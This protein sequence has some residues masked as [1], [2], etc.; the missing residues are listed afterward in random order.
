MP[1]SNVTT[2]HASELWINTGAGLAK[3]A[4]IDDIPELPTGSERALYETSSFDSVDY[5]EFK[6]EP[7][8]EGVEIEITGNYVINSA[9][10]AILQD[11]D[12]AEGALAYRIVL[13]EGA[14]TYHCEGEALF[15]NLKRMNP[16]AEKRTFSIMMKPVAAAAIDAA[17]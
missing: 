8:K 13:K 10:D 1:I 14:A 5:K 12:D 11:A 15:Y 3:V 2:G 6:K 4:E 17:A 16:K 7:L 9:A